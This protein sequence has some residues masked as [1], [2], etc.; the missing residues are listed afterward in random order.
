M[1]KLM[2]IFVSFM[3]LICSSL[4]AE[5]FDR[6]DVNVKVIKKILLGETDQEGS[7]I[8]AN[9]A[10]ATGQ[11][12]DIINSRMEREDLEI[13]TD[14]ERMVIVTGEFA[15]QIKR[16]L[17]IKS[18][19][20]KWIAFTD[21]IADGLFNLAKSQLK[22]YPDLLKKKLTLIWNRDILNGVTSQVIKSI[23]AG[24]IKLG[25]GLFLIPISIAIDAAFI[26]GSLCNLIVGAGAL[27]AV[28]ILEI[29][30]A[31]L[32]KLI[33]VVGLEV[34]K[35][36]KQIIGKLKGQSINREYAALRE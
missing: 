28:V 34:I 19:E 16:T 31:H 10:E 15:K 20:D 26:V 5:D 21:K 11:L 27:G 25:T 23:K 35:I 3:L 17:G 9:G 4:V 13:N 2:P 1:K 32:V 29:A 30:T 14:S 8:L 36:G 18:I 24:T 12:L 6:N 33:Q 7:M 22:N